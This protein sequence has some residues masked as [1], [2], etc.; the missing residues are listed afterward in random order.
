MLPVKSASTTAGSCATVV[1]RTWPW[2]IGSTTILPPRSRRNK[3][4]WSANGDP[5]IDSTGGSA[6]DCTLGWYRH[7][8]T[9]SKSEPQ[10]PDSYAH[11]RSLSYSRWAAI[12]HGRER[13]AGYQIVVSRSVEAAPGSFSSVAVSNR[14]SR[15]LQRL[16]ASTPLRPSRESVTGLS[17]LRTSPMR[18]RGYRPHYQ[19]HREQLRSAECRN[20]PRRDIPPGTES[21]QGLPGR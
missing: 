3:A 9:N 16:A 19:Q 21:I 5:D 10:A 15:R 4:G 14:S 17:K 11:R 12:D 8:D 1:I 20:L 6:F 13:D 7:Q 2:K 18:H